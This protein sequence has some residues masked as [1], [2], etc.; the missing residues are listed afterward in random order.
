MKWRELPWGWI[1]AMV[2]VTV[3][4]LV[5]GMLAFWPQMPKV[6]HYLGSQTMAAWVQGVGTI[7]AIAGAWAIGNRQASH[8]RQLENERWQREADLRDQAVNDRNAAAREALDTAFSC[9]KNIRRDVN[10]ITDSARFDPT[11]CLRW[12]RNAFDVLRYYSGLEQHSAALVIA[13]FHA[14]RDLPALIAALEEYNGS[15]GMMARLGFAAQ[16]A[17]VTIGQTLHELDHGLI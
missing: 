17:H 5:Y 6:L 8:Q 2:Y 16:T 4:P 12:A 10:A 15:G 7:A 9:C 3:A 14:Q 11:D 13:L 1:M